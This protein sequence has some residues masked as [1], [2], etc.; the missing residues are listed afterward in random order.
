MPINFRKTKDNKAVCSSCGADYS[1]SVVMY[2]YRI[3]KQNG[4]LCDLCLKELFS[5]ALKVTC[6][7]DK[8]SKDQRQVRVINIRGQKAHPEDPSKMSISKALRGVADDE[9]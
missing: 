6:L 2:E 9:D 7:I 4:V 3:G 5:K 8:E 1:E